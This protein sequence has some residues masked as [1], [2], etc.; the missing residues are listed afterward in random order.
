MFATKPG[1]FL[2]RTIVV[3]IPARLEQHVNLITLS[4]LNLVEQVYVMLNLYLYYLFHLIYMLNM[5]LYYLFH[6]IYMLN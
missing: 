2:I 3:L 6:F 5:Y 1:L 4:N